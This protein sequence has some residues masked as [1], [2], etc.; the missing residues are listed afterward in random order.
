MT[1]QTRRVDVYTVTE[2]GPLEAARVMRLATEYQAR[3]AAAQEKP[4]GATEEDFELLQ[5]L[6]VWPSV[7]ACMTPIP[8]VEDWLQIPLTT[9]EKLKGAAEIL[10]PSWFVAPTPATEKKTR[11]RHKPST[12]A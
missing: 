10:N 7:G 1:L 12:S 8:S 9:I 4:N 6:S 5:A 2:A 11:S 3:L